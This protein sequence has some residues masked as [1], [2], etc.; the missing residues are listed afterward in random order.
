MFWHTTRNTT[1]GDVLAHNTHTQHKQVGMFWLEMFVF[2]VLQMGT[3]LCGTYYFVQRWGSSAGTTDWGATLFVLL[4]GAVGFSVLC[5]LVLPIVTTSRAMYYF[6]ATG[7]PIG[8]AI[9]IFLFLV[10]S[11]LFN[12]LVVPAATILHFVVTA[13]SLSDSRF[14]FA[15]VML[16][17][18]WPIAFGFLAHMAFCSFAH[19]VFITTA[20]GS[21][22]L[23]SASPAGP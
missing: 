13:P 20:L 10:T 22:R 1:G 5:G 16:G 2:L 23:K 4:C 6:G 12:I 14:C 18:G 9:G 21:A 8:V 17:G 19:R 7:V 11:L 3:A 15:D